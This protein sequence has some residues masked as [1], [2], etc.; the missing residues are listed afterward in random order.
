MRIV[1]EIRED[2][3]RT[4]KT[5]RQVAEEMRQAAAVF[6][7]ARGDVAP[8]AVNDIVAPSAPEKEETLMDLLLSM[9][10]VGE[11]ADFER[12]LDYGRPTVELD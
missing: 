1:M 6:W 11:D 5:P 8:E 4:P 12:P 9:P 7:V 10:D 3:F 2:A